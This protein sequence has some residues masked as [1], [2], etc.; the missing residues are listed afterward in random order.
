MSRPTSSCLEPQWQSCNI[1]GDV[2]KPGVWNTSFCHWIVYALMFCEMMKELS[3]K[4]RKTVQVGKEQQRWV[5]GGGWSWKYD[6]KLRL[7]E[8]PMLKTVGW[9]WNILVL[10]D[11]KIWWFLKPF[12]LQTNPGWLRTWCHRPNLTNPSTELVFPNLE[13]LGLSI[14]WGLLAALDSLVSQAYGAGSQVAWNWRSDGLVL[15]GRLH[16]KS[17]NTK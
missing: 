16:L 11:G 1:Y 6:A 5:L 3:P 10:K 13:G 8:N 15:F 2:S 4:G 7:G 12:F 17:R 9:Y 14:G